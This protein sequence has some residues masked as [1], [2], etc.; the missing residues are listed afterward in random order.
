M[1]IFSFITKRRANTRAESRP[2]IARDYTT[3]PGAFYSA[4]DSTAFA[5]MDRIANEI[6][7]L[8]FGVF[9][10]RTKQ[11]V[12]NHPLL[13]LLRDPNLE[14][15]HQLF[16][17]QSVMDYFSGGVF[18]LKGR[19]TGGQ[20]V[21]LFRL[22]PAEAVRKRNPETNAR[23]YLYRGKVYT[24]R[25]ILFIP[26]RFNY[27]TLSGGTSIFQALRGTFNLS[28]EL[29]RFTFNSFKNG[30]GG[31]RTV[32]DIGQALP[33]ATQDEVES[34]RNRFVMDYSGVENAGKPLVKK[35]GIEYEV[36]DT[37][38]GDNRGAELS[39]QR[40]FQEHEMAKIFNVP[41]ALLTGG[42]EGFDL[43]TVFTLFC[44]FAL[45]P[46]ATQF[47]ESINTLIAD[48]A[49]FFEFDYNGILKVSLSKRVDAYIKQINNGLLSPDEARRKENMGS[50]E[51][52]DT[53]FMPANLMPLNKET[54]NAYMAKQKL[55]AQGLNG[56][57]LADDQHS[58]A[59]DDKQ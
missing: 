26:S 20:V 9:S 44:E 42:A 43:E 18:W 23:E 53:F 55:A 14:E 36:M 41:D 16:F 50:I 22:S 32:I 21:S 39:E 30:M 46:I 58:P 6:A 28:E 19:A 56:N 37:G 3:A 47:Q 40:R 52:G 17:Y 11:K 12:P 33:D 10:S 25:D 5:C 24:D 1:G 29:D 57:P 49:H 38:S 48:D 8:N 31:K 35:K 51:A 2:R 27:S 54:V 45:K 13:T 15:G 4:T 59:G 34:I 7:M